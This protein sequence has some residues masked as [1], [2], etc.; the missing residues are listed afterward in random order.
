MSLGVSDAGLKA[1]WEAAVG[2]GS[3]ITRRLG[4]EG[5]LGCDMKIGGEIELAKRGE[6]GP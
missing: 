6:I 5:L 3:S 4:A 2:A 1:A